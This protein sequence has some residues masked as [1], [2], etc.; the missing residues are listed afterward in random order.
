MGDRKKENGE[1]SQ[2]NRWITLGTNSDT[3]SHM[4]ARLGFRD[5]SH[6]AHTSRTMML[7]DLRILLENLPNHSTLDDYRQA[8]TTENLLG[9]PTGFSRQAALRHIQELYGLDSQQPVFRALRHFWPLEPEGQPLLALLCSVARDPL[10]RA[11]VEYIQSIP[12]GQS[13][14]SNDLEQWLTAHYPGRFKPTTLKSVAQNING[15]WTQAGFL[16]GKVR[17]VR[18]HPVVSTITAVY[19]LLLGYLEGARALNLLVSP[20]P[21]LLES[22]PEALQ[23]F[24]AT[25]SRRG[26]LNYRSAGDILEIQFDAWLL[27]LERECARE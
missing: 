12:I 26:W 9:K 19:A 4:R 3:H 24:A 18:I 7:S 22:D 11:S 23:E 21:M 8:I 6:G 10:L 25:A 13:V 5:G 15:T 20:Y 14:T 1:R 27:T 2:R 17:K 16:A